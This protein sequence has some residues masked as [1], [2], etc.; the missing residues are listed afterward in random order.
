[1]KHQPTPELREQDLRD[2]FNKYGL[3]YSQIVGEEN[4]VVSCSLFVFN[5]ALRDVLALFTKLEA[6]A[7]L[8]ELYLVKANLEG[9][10]I[11]Q[12]IYSEVKRR[13]KALQPPNST[14]ETEE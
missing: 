5:K 12:V 13:I 11:K 6:E 8:E 9:R 14:K 2:I 10:V 7:R 1:M 4:T 3:N